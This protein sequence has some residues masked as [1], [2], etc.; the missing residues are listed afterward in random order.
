[1]RVELTRSLQS[2]DFESPTST[3]RPYSDLYGTHG[4]IRTHNKLALNQS[5]LPV[6][7]HVHYLVGVAG[8]EPARSLRSRDFKSPVTTN[9]TTLRKLFGANSENRTRK[10]LWAADS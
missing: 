6:A 2:R 1:M 8:L 7:L 10:P 4:G 9:S 3:V 5:P